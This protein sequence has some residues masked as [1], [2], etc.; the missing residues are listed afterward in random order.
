V[1]SSRIALIV[2]LLLGFTLR[3]VQLGK[4]SL[5][6]DEAGVVLA[7]LEPSLASLLDFVRSHAVAVKEKSF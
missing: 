1:I 3:T 7:A 5:W 6:N 4:S 2:T